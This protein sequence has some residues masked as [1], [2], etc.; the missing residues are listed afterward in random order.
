MEETEKQNVF[1]YV[2]EQF[3]KTVIPLIPFSDKTKETLW[4]DTYYKFYDEPFI[5]ENGNVIHG[6]KTG[7]Q[8]QNFFDSFR[9]ELDYISRVGLDDWSKKLKSKKPIE[10]V[11]EI[12][13]AIYPLRQ[14]ELFSEIGGEG[15]ENGEKWLIEYLSNEISYHSIRLKLPPTPEQ[16]PGNAKPTPDLSINQIALKLAYEGL[17]VTRDNADEIVK[18]YNHN[19]GEKLFQKFTYY[20]NTANR[21]GIPNPPTAKKLQNKI[22]LFESVIELLQEPNKKRAINE[23][24]ILKTT[25]ENEF[26]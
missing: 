7:W 5:L 23:L 20:S 24:K 6:I 12:N 2:F 17:R 19:S 21:K 22:E 16:E 25:F 8:L 4:N 1:D 26:E 13:Q 9:S 11:S 3:V 18:Q 14:K 15:L 10:A